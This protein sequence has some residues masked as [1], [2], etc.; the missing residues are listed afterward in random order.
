MTDI[1]V[2]AQAD[3]L[4]VRT[5]LV[6]LDQASALETMLLKAIRAGAD[7]KDDLCDV[8]GLAPR[9]VEGIL[10][11]LWRA[12]R[13]SI[14]LGTDREEIKLTSGARKELDELTEGQAVS[15]SVDRTGSEEVA[16]DRLTGRVL[17][18]QATRRFLR[19]HEQGLV[20]PTMADDPDSADLRES[21]LAEAVTRS[22][23]WRAD[24][25]PGARS[26]SA[27]GKA[28][29]PDE[30]ADLVGNLRIDTAYLAPALLRMSRERRYVPLRVRVFEDA[31]G[32]LT[33]RVTDDRLPLWAREQ[34][35]RRLTGLIADRPASRFVTQLKQHAQHTPVRARDL[36]QLVTELR[37]LADALPA[38]DRGNRQREHDRATFLAGEIDRYT[39]ALALTEMDVTVITTS[40]QHR[41]AIVGMLQRAER[42]VVIAVPWVRRHGMLAIRD[43][44]TA[45]VGRGIQITFLWGIASDMQQLD[46]DLLANLDEIERHARASGRGGELRYHRT[47]GAH[48]H[49]K[50]VVADDREL[51]V[52]SKNFLS[53]SDLTEAGLLLT[54]P[55]G[56]PGKPPLT[57]PVIL[58]VLKFLYDH[59]PDPATAFQLIHAR[60]GFGSR[61]D[62]PGLPP[63]PL[64]RLTAAVLDQNAPPE[65]VRAWAA[66]WQEA[67]RTLADRAV[68]SR[69]TVE[70]IKDGQH[71]AL[72]REAL[73]EAR[74]RVLITSHR[75]SKQALT[76][77]VCALAADRAAQGVDV[78]VRYGV[79]T[80]DESAARLKRLA[81]S[82][83]LERAGVRLEGAMHAKVVIRDSS[84]VLGS[85]NHLSVD[86][87]V[88][89][90]R[91]TGELSVRIASAAVAGKVW[92]ALLGRSA[93][94]PSAPPTAA[95]AAQ[96]PGVPVQRL[97]ELLEP[98]GGLPDVD[99]LAALV[100]A[101]GTDRVLAAVHHMELGA[102][103]RRRVLAAAALPV[104][105]GPSQDR[106]TRLAALMPAIWTAGAWACADQV[107]RHIGRFRPLSARRAHR[108]PGGPGRAR[109][110]HLGCGDGGDRA[111]R[112]RGRGPGRV[113]LRGTA[114]GRAHRLRRGGPAARLGA[115]ACA[116]Q[117]RV[118]RRGGRLPGPL[119]RTAG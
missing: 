6:P 23:N 109:P 100:R 110:D 11:D 33:V 97:L 115:A 52:T 108:R 57:C 90:R 53:G 80:D 43:A 84:T 65:H 26:P 102:G 5:T 105:A 12:G 107:R 27:A 38:C 30:P 49:A 13:I 14:E 118:R 36:G 15:T 54:A 87:G 71:A 60:E 39:E 28:G 98:L 41:D 2:W 113:R 85:F 19:E 99:A 92:A 76:D 29:E 81:A 22:L 48:S 40:E 44:L 78:A 10:G 116:A 104:L 95:E 64:P 91:A 9:L 50:V 74:H 17:P 89:G 32:S 93:R 24:D 55:P 37:S 59:V 88:R 114:A 86:A 47:R 82:P 25:E 68:R 7:H 31:A 56:R 111:H 73:E 77:E 69:P 96:E 67:A 35:A 70:V 63:V 8:F 94:P 101:E 3:I 79:L 112:G 58:E 46:S 21:D 42:Q 34:A 75:V 106:D 117:R 103:P 62:K 119:R 20:V 66:A 83:G 45:A 1:E 16:H 4:N 51:L 61:Q 72:V 18:W